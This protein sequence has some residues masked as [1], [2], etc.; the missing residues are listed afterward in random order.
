MNVNPVDLLFGG[1][2]KLAPGDNAHTQ[3]VLRLLSRKRFRLVVDAGSGTGRQTV[4]LAKELGTRVHAVDTHQP[5]LD[6]LVQRARDAGVEHLVQAHHID[7]KD[8]PRAFQDID[9]LWSEGAAYNIGFP[10][11]LAIW[12]P[13][14]AADGLAVISE[15][16]WLKERPPHA[17]REFFRSG[18][19]EMRSVNQNVAVAKQAGYQLLTTHTLPAEAWVDWLLRR[20]RAACAGPRGAPGSIGSSV[21][22][23]HPQ[24]NRG[25][26]AL[27][28]QLR[29]RVLRPSTGQPFAGPD[30][31]R[32]TAE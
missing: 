17:V 3:H 26:S 10:H 16:S 9:L 30:H 12:H 27:R 15:L 11:A 4:A 25:V 31:R 20:S 14:L 19:P 24:G 21:R 8:I 22:R 7:M 18:Y 32:A 29:V 6:E 13:A 23:R 5:F 28:G 1:M 2:E